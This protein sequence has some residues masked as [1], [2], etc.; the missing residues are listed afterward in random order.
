MDCRFNP[1]TG[2]SEPM[3]VKLGEYGTAPECRGGGNGRSP[4][5]PAYQR[6]CLARFPHATRLQDKSLPKEAITT[7]I[8]ARPPPD[9]SKQGSILGR[10]TPGFSHVGM[11]PDDASGRQ[12]FSR[13]SRS[14]RS[15]I[16]ALLHTHLISPSSALKTSLLRAAQISQLSTG[17]DIFPSMLN[18][19]REELTSLKANG[20]LQSKR[21]GRRSDWPPRETQVGFDVQ[22]GLGRIL[23]PEG[24]FNTDAPSS[25]RLAGRE[26]LNFPRHERHPFINGSLNSS[27]IVAQSHWL[28]YCP[29]RIWL[30]EDLRRPSRSVRVA[31]HRNQMY[32]KLIMRNFPALGAHKKEKL[33][34]EKD[35]SFVV[36]KSG[37]F[38]AR[39]AGLA[40]K[41][42]M[43]LGLFVVGMGGLTLVKPVENKER[44]FQQDVAAVMLIT[45]FYL[46]SRDAER[47]GV[48]TVSHIIEHILFRTR[49]SHLAS[50]QG[51]PG[52]IPGQVTGSSQV[53]I[54]PDDAVGRRVFSGIS[55]FSRPIIP[56]PLHVHFNNPHRLSRPRCQEPPKSL[57]FTSRE[58]V[59][60]VNHPKKH[61][62]GD[63]IEM[64]SSR[65]GGRPEA[66]RLYYS[67]LS[68]RA[69]AREVQDAVTELRERE[70]SWTSRAE[71]KRYSGGGCNPV[72][73]LPERI[74]Q[75]PRDRRVLVDL[76]SGWRSK[77]GSASSGM[78]D[79]PSLGPWEARNRDRRVLSVSFEGKPG[80]IRS[81]VAPGFSHVGIVP[82]DAAVWRVFSGNF[83]GNPH[84]LSI[85]RF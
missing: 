76:W 60:H 18:A 31:Q 55:R 65:I 15:C 52:S 69:P 35:G 84:R 71:G 11:V 21:K 26:V 63:S 66:T 54:V 37:K 57:H 43:W 70:G 7:N 14:P 32:V 41:V 80:S 58:S 83:S 8:I 19:R 1:L 85:P 73:I 3:R 64:S 29:R 33:Y 81:G 20:L 50:Y 27:Q 67:S 38:K 17:S 22:R 59:T 68:G 10:V 62:L 23:A 30:F 5:K 82:D 53:G 2:V 77:K 9:Q 12:V 40:L 49:E 61:T 79:T 39:K 46:S 45:K 42:L 48:K 25:R 75:A 36:R 56:I 72:L 28:T 47:W 51:E 4:R 78:H 44:N 74:T 24:K 16:P 34:V 6:H 13:F